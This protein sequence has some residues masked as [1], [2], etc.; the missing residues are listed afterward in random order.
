MAISDAFQTL[1]IA[2]FP[3][4]DMCKYNHGTYALGPIQQLWFQ[5]RACQISA[6]KF[7][8]VRF[9]VASELKFKCCSAALKFHVTQF[10]VHKSEFEITYRFGYTSPS[11]I[12]CPLPLAASSLSSALSVMSKTKNFS[13]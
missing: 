11:P 1:E 10:Q 3:M 4:A 7:E 12:A 9:Q 13:G 8:I 2:N 5:I 6:L